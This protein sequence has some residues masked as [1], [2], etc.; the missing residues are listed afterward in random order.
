MDVDDVRARAARLLERHA[1][2]LKSRAMEDDD[3]DSQDE[4]E[5]GNVNVTS[6]RSDDMQREKANEENEEEEEEEEDESMDPPA[7]PETARAAAVELPAGTQSTD[8]IAPSSSSLASRSVPTPGRGRQGRQDAENVETYLLQRGRESQ[9]QLRRAALEAKR[10]EASEYTFAPTI[11][12]KAQNLLREEPVVVRLQREHLR[13]Q[14]ALRISREEQQREAENDLPTFTPHINAGSGAGLVGDVASR[15]TAWEERRYARR[16]ESVKQA[17]ED[18]EAEM[19]DNPKINKYSHAIAKRLIEQGKRSA[20]VGEHLHSLG[21]QMEASRRKAEE[22]MLMEKFPGSPSIT[23]MAA[24]LHR[25]G[26]VGDRLYQNAVE[27]QRR[28][29]EKAAELEREKMEKS[30]FVST[31]RRGVVGEGN[32]TPEK[33]RQ[34]GHSLYERAVLS[35]QKKKLM[36]EK[37][38]EDAQ[39]AARPKLSKRSLKIASTMEDPRERLSK[40]RPKQVLALELLYEERARQVDE[41]KKGARLQS[42]HKSAKKS[43]RL[44]DLADQELTYKPAVDPISEK[45]SELRQQGAEGGYEKDVGTRLYNYRKKYRKDY[46]ERKKQNMLKELE[47]CTFRPNIAPSRR[48]FG[49]VHGDNGA[50]TDSKVDAAES[51][52]AG[53]DAYARFKKWKERRDKKVEQQTLERESKALKDCTFQPNLKSRGGTP[54]KKAGTGAPSNIE[55]RISQR[56]VSSEA[57]DLRSQERRKQTGNAYYAIPDSVLNLSGMTPDMASSARSIA[58]RAVA[59]AVQNQMVLSSEDK[60]LRVAARVP[61]SADDSIVAHAERM[62]RAHAERRYKMH[63]DLMNQL[64]NDHSYHGY[65]N[66]NPSVIGASGVPVS[67]PVRPNARPAKHVPKS[68]FEKALRMP[69][70]P[71][72]IKLQ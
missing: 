52:K 33:P 8:G 35:A 15:T 66:E 26:S 46:S 62:R 20:N 65:T 13:Q 68:V 5:K 53:S 67:I 44:S 41:A 51:S 30:R 19:Q 24:E 14:E 57:M 21:A 25:E 17:E 37:Q 31:N 50:Q 29:E 6:H 22:D 43:F 36:R 40:L 49:I 64:R 9:A 28:R 4:Q 47:D 61:L 63:S 16:A 48:T 27:M 45:I 11:S 34:Q 7:A 1:E 72:T 42:H 10:E 3:S 32:A 12:K 39:N 58:D 59:R 2:R 23:R 60:T 70:K 69:V 54:K 56:R 55:R 18:I 71:G 38:L